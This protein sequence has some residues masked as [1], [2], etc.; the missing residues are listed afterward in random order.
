MGELPRRHFRHGLAHAAAQISADRRADVGWHAAIVRARPVRCGGTG[1]LLM[2]GADA[3][4]KLKVVGPY[5][6]ASG[7]D[8]LTREFVREF[9]RRSV[10]VELHDLPGWSIPLPEHAHS[11]FD[12]FGSPL[13]AK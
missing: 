8:R 7:Y 4:R 11:V 9:V 12:R 6:G 13:G 10:R 1:F 3:S 5:K 2:L